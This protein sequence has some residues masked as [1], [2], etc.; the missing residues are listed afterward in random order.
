MGPRNGTRQESDDP[1]VVGHLRVV[2]LAGA[3]GQYCGKILADLGADVI[4]RPNQLS[5]LSLQTSTSITP[6]PKRRRHVSSE[7]MESR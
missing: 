5:D 1:L 7:Q 4:K 3:K 2:D 6:I